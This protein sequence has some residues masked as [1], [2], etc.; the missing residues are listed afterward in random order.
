MAFLYRFVSPGLNALSIPAERIDG[1]VVF[2][3]RMPDHF[4][5]FTRL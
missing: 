5:T 3:R 1:K 2:F 4:L